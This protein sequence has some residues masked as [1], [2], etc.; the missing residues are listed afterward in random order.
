MTEESFCR[1]TE[2]SL[3]LPSQIDAAAVVVTAI[4]CNGGEENR[5][6]DKEN[7][8]LNRDHESINATES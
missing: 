7:K 4:H 3:N 6:E 8:H 5:G 2:W 1:R